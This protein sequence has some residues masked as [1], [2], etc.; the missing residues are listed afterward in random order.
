MDQGRHRKEELSK[1]LAAQRQEITHGRTRVSVA[2]DP[3][4]ML[5]SSIGQH[6][7]GWFAGS[8]GTAAVTSF[9]FRRPKV[10]VADKIKVKR[11]GIVR[12]TAGALFGIAKPLLLKWALEKSQ[13]RLLPEVMKQLQNHEKRL[14]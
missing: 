2:M 7:L 10:I 6:P 13:E 5:R 8:L 1:L 4:Q 12:W 14:R 9:L 3:G 11:K